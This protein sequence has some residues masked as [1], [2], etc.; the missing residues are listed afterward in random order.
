M[1]ALAL[2]LPG[3]QLLAGASD[4]SISVFDVVSHQLLRAVSPSSS[5]PGPVTFLRALLRPPD[6]VG[7]ASAG[8]TSR[9][10]W[11]STHQTQWAC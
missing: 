11:A 5:S 2:D 7:P 1:T 3:T 4:G 9:A 10:S 6:L 8:A